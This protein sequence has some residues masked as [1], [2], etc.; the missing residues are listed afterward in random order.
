MQQLSW[1]EMVD[2]WNT[3][4]DVVQGMQDYLSMKGALDIAVR[5]EKPLPGVLY[6][7]TGDIEAQL[8]RAYRGLRFVGEESV[9]EI[10]RKSP[11]TRYLGMIY[12]T[13]GSGVVARMQMS[14]QE[15]R[16]GFALGEALLTF[17]AVVP[18]GEYRAETEKALAAIWPH[19]KGFDWVIP[20]GSGRIPREKQGDQSIILVR[21]GKP[22]AS[23]QYA[24]RESGLAIKPKETIKMAE[25][26][27]I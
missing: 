7:M 20:D 11:G 4:P 3:S 18:L 1:P 21:G 22:V 12:G 23:G 25:G 17:F 19:I 14:S 24:I 8:A 6:K 13:D 10:N 9:N 2:A 16:V 26:I 5:R 15:T 27:V